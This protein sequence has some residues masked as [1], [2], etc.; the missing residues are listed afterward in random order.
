MHLLKRISRKTLY[1]AIFCLLLLSLAACAVKYNPVETDSVTVSN[2]HAIIRNEKYNLITENRHWVKEPQNLS[3]YFTTFY[4]TIQ[5]RTSDN[6]MVSIDE[7]T[8]LDEEGN[9]YDALHPDN[10]VKL[11]IPEEI[12]FDPVRELSHRQNYQME[13]WRE[14]RRNLMTD[15]L[16]FG[17]VL[18]GA[19]K[20][21]FIFFPRVSSRNR[22]LELICKDYRIKFTR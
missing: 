11:L 6:L 3:N 7:F 1:K 13:Q 17:A 18:P 22:K 15:S 12:I 8:L 16:N 4:V 2:G 14:A 10:V 21:G 19:R 9:Q 20:S 5:N